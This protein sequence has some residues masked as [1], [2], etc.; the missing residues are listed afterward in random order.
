MRY[1]IGIDEVGRGPLAGPVVLAAVCIPEGVR[2]TSRKLGKLR[3]SKKLSEKKRE[4]WSAYLRSH[5]RVKFALARINPRKIEKL[6]ISQAANRAAYKA[7]AKLINDGKL[8]LSSC[9]I[10]LDGGL[11]ARSGKVSLI[12]KTIIKGDEKIPAIKM[13]SIFAKVQRDN[14]MVKMAKKYPEYGFEKHKGY[15]TKVHKAA[16]KKYGPSDIHRLTF[17]APYPRISV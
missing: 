12:S 14:Y 17:L 15:A 11:Y 4:E 1:V 7:C 3:D 6:N 9:K 10:Y 8:P 13:A 16:L 2:I 5:P